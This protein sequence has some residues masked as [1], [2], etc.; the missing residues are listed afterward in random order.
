MNESC[1]TYEWVMWH[2]WMIR[3]THMD[4]SR[5][6]YEWV[7]PQNWTSHIT[8]MNESW[9]LKKWLLVIYGCVMW[10]IWMRHATH[11]DGSCHTHERVMTHP[12][13]WHDSFICVTWLSLSL[14]LAL[15]LS[16]SVSVSVS[17]S[18]SLSFS[19]S[20]THTLP[21][22]HLCSTTA[23]PHFLPHIEFNH[24]RHVS[25]RQ[26]RLCEAYIIALSDI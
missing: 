14:A 11:M 20:P 10:H 22:Q 2:K 19:L 17:L 26:T 7:M 9:T 8:H 25:E 4:E 1:H 15:A 23:A 13:V 21:V 18:L 16:L 12:Y 3:I 6:T 5:H 24:V